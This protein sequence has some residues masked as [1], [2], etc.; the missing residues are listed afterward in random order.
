[1]TA[2]GSGSENALVDQ[3]DKKAQKMCLQLIKTNSNRMD[4]NKKIKPFIKLRQ[5]ANVIQQHYSL[6]YKSNIQYSVDCGY[7]QTQSN[8]SKNIFLTMPSILNIAFRTRVLGKPGSGHAK[9]TTHRTRD[10]INCPP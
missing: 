1:M 7:G 8:S 9:E 2:V 4:F 5:R 10:H 3:S 6:F